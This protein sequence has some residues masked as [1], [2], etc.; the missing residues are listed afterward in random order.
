VSVEK[1][2]SKREAAQIAG[3]SEKT[4]D[5]AIKRGKLRRANNGVRRVRI[6][7]SDLVRWLNGGKVAGC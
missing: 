4:I 5:R 2:C 1:W 7:Y 3:L 6:A